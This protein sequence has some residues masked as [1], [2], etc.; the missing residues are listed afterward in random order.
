M[1]DISFITLSWNSDAY[2]QRCLA[3][4][5]AQCAT[6]GLRAE[7]L[8]VDNGSR[9][10]SVETVR[11]FAARFP[12]CVRLMELG[13]NRGT[14]V[15]RNL[16][17]KQAQAPVLCVIDS[18]TEYLS[19]S[20]RSILKLLR[21]DTVGIV[22]PRLVLPDGSVQ[23]SVKR[24]PTFVDKLRKVPRIL[25]GRPVPRTDFY[26]SFPFAGRTPVESAISACWFFRKDLLGCVGFLDEAIFYAP[27]DV[28]FS[29]R[30]WKSGHQVVYEPGFTLLHHTQQVSH[31]RPVSRLALS[32]L[33]GLIHYHRVH[34]GW[35]RRPEVAA[36]AA[37]MRAP[38][39]VRPSWGAA[40]LDAKVRPAEVPQT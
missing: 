11:A 33:K 25:T 24:F 28:D 23:H 26:A 15:P 4:I 27:E 10:G 37:R 7:I 13:Q 22:A 21:D 39:R 38:G 19:G 5:M 1:F 32:H 34:G 8:V 17:L 18:D 35:V 40:G 36:A 3:S 29:I 20:L 6:E 31:R 12:G 9:D 30:V 14:T 2:L 16:A